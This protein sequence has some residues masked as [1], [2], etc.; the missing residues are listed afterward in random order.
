[1]NS[2]THSANNESPAPAPETDLLD[3]TQVNAATTSTPN[4]SPAPVPETDLLDTTQVNAAT[5]G[6]VQLNGARTK[7]LFALGVNFALRSLLKY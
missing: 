7:T 2:G 5:T 4:D 6:F 3:T 1:M